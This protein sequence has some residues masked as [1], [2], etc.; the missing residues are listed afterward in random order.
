MNRKRK[1]KLIGGNKFT[2]CPCP[3]G[4][5]GCYGD[6]ECDCSGR[7]Q[8]CVSQGDVTYQVKNSKNY[9]ETIKNRLKNAMNTKKNNQ[10]RREKVNRIMKRMKN[11]KK[12]NKKL[13][14]SNEYIK[15][16]K[17]GEKTVEIKVLNKNTENIKEGDIIEF[18]GN[19]NSV[20]VK[21]TGVSK[22]RNLRKALREGTIKR[23]LP[24]N[25]RTYDE[26][27]KKLRETLGNNNKRIY[28]NLT[29]ELIE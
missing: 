7:V 13:R 23:T 29:L 24:N 18:L 16:I 6:V 9:I 22:H 26:G 5:V 15:E 28:L 20:K 19:N 21:I 17:N 8:T 12:N 14:L 1:S 25:V 11:T 4:G 3:Q 10:K 27:V 2:F